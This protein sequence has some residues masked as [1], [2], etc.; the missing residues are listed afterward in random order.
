MPATGP[1]AALSM[2]GSRAQEIP[3]GRQRPEREIGA[4]AVILEIEHA[5]KARRRVGRITPETIALLGAPQIFD[6]TAHCVRTAATRRQQR[7]QC[8]RSLIGIAGRAVIV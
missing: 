3:V 5:R 7:Q 6:A 1:P 8:P 4:V 2:T